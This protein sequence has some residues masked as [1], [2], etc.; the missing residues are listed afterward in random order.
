MERNPEFGVPLYVTFSFVYFYLK[1][2]KDLPGQDSCFGNKGA[3]DPYAI[4]EILRIED[5]EN[6]DDLP[7]LLQS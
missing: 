1:E 4:I 5:P 2:A 6:R 3:V 7:Q